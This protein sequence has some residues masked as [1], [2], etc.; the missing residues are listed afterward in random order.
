METPL[1]PTESYVERLWNEL[2]ELEQYAVKGGPVL[3]SNTQSTFAKAM[4]LAAGNWLERRTMQAIL[5]FTES[6]S[7][8][9][10][11]VA[12]IKTTVLKRKFHTLF[13]W[14][15]G[16]VNSFLGLFG[17][18]FRKNVQRA[19]PQNTSVHRASLDFMELCSER[20]Q[21]A[22]NKRLG[23]EAQFTPTEVRTKFYNAAGWV[24]WIGQFLIQGSAPSWKPP[25]APS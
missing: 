21:L 12:L 16:S 23:D 9:E 1:Q 5:D 8:N 15:S 11:L 13:D 18:N 22:H 25:S 14:N 3:V 19:A 4:I 2:G 24:S 7:C 10:I 6:T 20:N 17:K